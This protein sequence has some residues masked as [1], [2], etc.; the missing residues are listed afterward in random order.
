MNIAATN[1]SVFNDSFVFQITRDYG[2][3]FE[4]TPKLGILNLSGCRNLTDSGIERATFPSLRFLGLAHCNVGVLSI[5]CSIREHE[6]FAMCVEGIALSSQDIELLLSQFPD[7]AEVGVPSL[8]GLPQGT[9]SSQAL[10]PVCYYCRSSPLRTV[11]TV[12]QST[13]GSWMEL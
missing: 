13:S 8:C 11:L 5:I 7:I 9:I 3:N 1:C 4:N 2:S 12:E 10:S 6:I